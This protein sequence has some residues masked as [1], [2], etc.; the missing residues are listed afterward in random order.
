[1]ISFTN[2][3]TTN[4]YGEERYYSYNRFLKESFGEKVYKIALDGGF[5]CPNRDGT[6]S[7]GG[8][9]FCSEGGSGDFAEGR[10]LS[11]SEQI[12]RGKDQ[13][14]KKYQGKKYIAYFQAYTNTYAPV[15]KLRMLY[16]EAMAPEEIAAIAIGTRPDCL[17]PEVW[18]LLEELNHR[19]PVH[20]ELG[21][22]SCHEE[23]AVLINRGYRTPVF[24][25]AVREAH[26][27]GIR[28]CAHLIL[29]LPGE[30]TKQILATIDYIDRL[31]VDAVKLS[32]LHV[33]KN[34]EL[35]RMYE[36]GEVH[37][38]TPE[39]YMDCLFACMEHLRP[40]I[41]IER[42][43]GDGPKSILIGPEWTGNKRY[44]MNTIRREMKARDI[45]Q[46]KQFRAADHKK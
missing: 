24:E 44:V 20:L 2:V 34:T 21:L 4:P 23:T 14:K 26:K 7:C 29:G 16:E 25:A 32:M 9:I 30:D 31:P 12:A 6:I 8:C 3:S 45:W 39:S 11:I 27:R 10:G 5:S 43:T 22:Q 1:M 38:Y 28:V 35:A 17:P 40:D 41:V 19:K 15:E 42:I 37:L 13:T 33:L 18:D 36:R 46:G